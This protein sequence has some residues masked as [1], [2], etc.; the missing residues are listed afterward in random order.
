M[1]RKNYIGKVLGL[2]KLITLHASRFT[3]Y[4]I[5]RFT[6]YDL[7]SLLRFTLHTLRFT[8][9][10]A[11]LFTLYALPVSTLAADKLV[12]MNGSTN[13][14]KVTDTGNVG[15]G[16]TNPGYPLEIIKN[17]NGATYVRIGNSNNGTSAVQGIYVTNDTNKGVS[18]QA[19]STNFSPLYA[20]AGVIR[21]DSSITNGFVFATGAQAPIRFFIK[22]IEQVRIDSSGNVGIGT[23]NPSGKLDVNGTIY[24]SGVPCCADYVFA[25]DYK[26]ES[27]E[28][29]AKFMWEKAHLKAIPKARRDANGNEMVEIG[30]TYQKGIVEE[31]EKAH[32]YIERLNKKIKDLEAKMKALE[33]GK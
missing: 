29:H 9:F 28:D 6:I 23:A 4:G 26:L 2:R 20:N 32:I 14:F 25:K 31:L 1:E 17:Q 27:I 21:T 7:R 15:I 16:T 11:L 8:V 30:G 22:D 19:R 13:L 3:L 5:K 10:F 12:V 33:E 24:Q 18:L